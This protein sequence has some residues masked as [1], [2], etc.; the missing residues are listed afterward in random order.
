MRISVYVASLCGIVAIGSVASSQEMRVPAAPVPNIAGLNT[1]TP[2]DTVVASAG[3]QKITAGEIRRT[4]AVMSPQMQQ[5]YSANPAGF[6][7]TLLVIKDL[8]A[9]A[10]KDHL[11][12]QSPLKE[13]LELS[14]MNTLSNA[15][16]NAR[17]N[18][19]M[20]TSDEQEK[21][22]AQHKDRYRQAKVKVI[23]IAFSSG[24]VKS[25]NKSLTEAEAKSKI[26]DLRKQALGGA[27]FGKL[28]RENS[29]D[30]ETATKDG[31]WG[32]IKGNS[33]FSDEIKKTVLSL[34]DGE[35]SEPIKQANG[36]YIFRAE[37]VS[38]QPYEEV[39][40]QIYEHLKQ[41]RFNAWMKDI[42]DRNKVKLEN[43]D[44]FSYKPKTAAAR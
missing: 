28:A 19:L 9:Q 30:K 15:E 31:D 37:Q 11:D 41:E 18:G 27:D 5:G 8:A 44:F 2:D 29:Q 17:R 33:T 3:N 7:Q 26:E 20:V 25:G 16:V 6:L 1:D 12:Q 10:E 21:Y 43:A 35:I 42:Q 38:T 40:E 36:F 34:K 23:Y 22:Y 14:R 24:Q 32:I 13:A 39:R 4:L